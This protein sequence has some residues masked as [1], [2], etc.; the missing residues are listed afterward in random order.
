[1]FCNTLSITETLKRRKM[2]TIENIMKRFQKAPA[3]LAAL[4]VVTSPG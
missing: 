2:N 1:M 4:E 3:F